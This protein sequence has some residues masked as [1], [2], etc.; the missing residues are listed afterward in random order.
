MLGK[1]EVVENECEREAG[2]KYW[3]ILCAVLSVSG[4]IYINY[5][6]YIFKMSHMIDR[7]VCYEN[8]H[9][10]TFYIYFHRKYM[11]FVYAYPCWESI[12]VGALY[13]KVKCIHIILILLVVLITS[14]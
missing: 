1:E 4:N 2:L 10:Q 11:C 7:H 12:I 5:P 14:I 13:V 8:T 3:L 6:N 9:M